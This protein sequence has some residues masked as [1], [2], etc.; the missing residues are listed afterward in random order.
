M[1]A[2]VAGAGGPALSQPVA[3]D[4]MQAVK[5]QPGERIVLDGS[6]SHPAWQRAPV[7]TR[8]VQKDPVNGVAPPQDT[9][10]QVLFDAQALYVGVTV[11]DT[12]PQK[13]RDLPVRLDQVNRTQ[14]FVVVYIDAIGRKRSAQFF[15]VNAAG[16]QADGMHTASDD[17]E[18]FS[19]D[20]DWDAAVQRNPQ[21][22]TAVLRLPFAALRFAEGAPGQEAPWR[23]MVARRIPRE[24]FHL[25]AS[26]PIPRGVASFIDTMQPLRGVELPQ[27]HHFLTLRPSITLRQTRQQDS[28]QPS[29]RKNDIDLS[30][31]LKYRASA[32]L[33]VDA[34]LNPDFSQVALDVPQLAGNTRF[35]LFVNE[36]RPFFLESF[37]LLRTPSD[38]IYTRSFT[39]P[40]LGLRAS[41]R[42]LHWSG[43]AMALD[44][45]GGGLLQLPGPYGTDYADQPGSRTLLARFKHDDGTAQWGGMVAAR[46]YEQGRGDNLVAGPDVSLPLDGS[47]RLRGQLLLSQTTALPGARGLRE[48]VA[49]DGHQAILKFNRNGESGE[50]S[51]TLLDSAAGFRHDSGFVN[52]TGVREL[53]F[54]HGHGW[55]PLGPF[56]EF[57]LNIEADETRDRSSGQL[58]KRVLRPGLWASAARNLQWELT[59]FGLSQLRTAPGAPL[60]REN[61]LYSGLL[62]SPATWWP[63][64]DTNVAIGRLADTSADR[65]RQGVRW[66]FMSRLRPLRSLELEPRWS[67]AWLDADGRKTYRDSAG[68]LLAVWHFDARRNLRL[69]VQRTS[70]DRRAE[71][72]VAAQRAAGQSTSLTYSWRQS[73]G[74]VLYLGASQSRDGRPT[75]QRGSEAFVKL[76]VDVEELRDRF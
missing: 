44:D 32:E 13:I 2:L 54:F 76:Q 55:F 66:N 15:R 70:L 24:Q 36:K 62:Y 31:D 64:L 74:T 21:G 53:K 69:I 5:L 57:F 68:Q 59:W 27:A 7:W 41:W 33:V 14:D 9:R 48:G 67:L 56:N 58:V 37:D 39:A 11:L 16:S 38:A 6:L 42:D 22:W 50:T 25:V 8:F 35:A 52:Q 40:R 10:V 46:R 51:I 29:Q 4:A 20:F 49:R 65:V 23:I 12:E 19:P 26:V 34:T 30:L 1:L 43:V 61:Y 3:D 63:M 71:P 45:R 18:D 60:L 73:S 28:G 17:N 47:W 75:A 72:G